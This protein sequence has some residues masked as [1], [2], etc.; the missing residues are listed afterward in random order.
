MFKKLATAI[1]W[2]ESQTKYKPKTDL[3]RMQEAYKYLDIDLS[4]ITKV[5]VAGTNGKGSTCAFL[6]RMCQFRGHKVGIFSSPY[7][8]KFN[9]RIGIGTNYIT[10]DELLTYINWVYKFN[11]SF[12]EF[13]KETL[14]FFELLTIMAMKYFNDQNVDM[15]IMEVGIGGLLDATN[16]L[17]YDLSLITNIGYDHMHILGHTL[18]SIAKNK[19]GIV[20]KGNHLITT[21]DEELHDLFKTYVKNVGAT[22]QFIDEKPIIENHYPL[23]IIYKEMHI[24][25]HLK[26]IYQ[27]KNAILAIEAAKYLCPDIQYLDIRS[28]FSK[29]KLPARQTVIRPG[30]YVDGAHNISA[31]KALGEHLKLMK[32]RRNVSILFS[33][34]ADKDVNGMLD[35]LEEISDRIIIT[36]FPD[37]RFKSLRPYLR[38]KM[39][40]NEDALG[41]YKRL[42]EE[43][44]QS[45][46]VYILGSLHFASYMMKEISKY[47]HELSLMNEQADKIECKSL[48]DDDKDIFE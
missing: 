8:L 32:P 1:T 14:S 40:Y 10:D 20:K 42:I 19:L 28:A 36:E 15:M 47:N 24:Y 2:I 5:Q 45:N 43:K 7:V 18:E 9:E 31:M 25:I 16:V 22:I 39:S 11:Q 21:V 33:C 13:Y 37:P 23:K 41:A 46:N 6:T 17:N 30:V 26:G 44:D 29:V 12:N 34:L 35:I 27:V 48:F 3:K 38:P 4:N